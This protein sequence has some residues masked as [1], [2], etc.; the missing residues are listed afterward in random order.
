MRVYKYILT[1]LVIFTV[2][3]CQKTPE[4]EGTDMH[5]FTLEELEKKKLDDAFTVF[6]KKLDLEGSTND[7]TANIIRNSRISIPSVGTLRYTYV[8]NGATLI[9]MDVRTGSF[10]ADLYGGIYLEGKAL[11]D[12][13]TAVYIDGEQIATLDII[14][15]KDIPTPVFRFPDGTTYAITGVL[16]VEPLI[17]FL[18]QNVFSTE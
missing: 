9:V 4:T 14:C 15:Y 5:E 3:G 16:L 8:K 13:G 17:D 10:T 1:I 11:T 6:F 2:A 7:I 18:L 12:A